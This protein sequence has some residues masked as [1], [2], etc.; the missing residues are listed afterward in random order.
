VQRAIKTQEPVATILDAVAEWQHIS[1]NFALVEL[2][3]I[4][5]ARRTFERD[6]LANALREIT[7][8]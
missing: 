6:A 1:R 8:T 7:V 4:Q 2:A 3:F 5:G